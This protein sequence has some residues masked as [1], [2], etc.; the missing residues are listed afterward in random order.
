MDEAWHTAGWAQVGSDSASHFFAG[1][2]YPLCRTWLNW[3][4][5]RH[6]V[7]PSPRCPSCSAE[8]ASS[9]DRQT[10]LQELQQVIDDAIP[11]A[12]RG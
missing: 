5:P 1:L 7:P 9:A 12:L 6:P 10:Y 2:A 11:P 4:T 3:G 8:L